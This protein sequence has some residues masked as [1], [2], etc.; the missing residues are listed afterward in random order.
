MALLQRQRYRRSFKRDSVTLT[1]RTFLPERSRHASRGAC[2]KTKNKNL[3]AMLPLQRPLSV[4]WGFFF[5]FTSR[6][7]PIHLRTV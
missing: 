7:A 3:H 4:L 2:K 5:P 6:Q 1:M